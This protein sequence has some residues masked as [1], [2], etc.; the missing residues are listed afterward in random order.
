MANPVSV[1]CLADVWT[2][3]A[4]NV[5]SGTI[6]KQINSPAK[7]V[8]TYKLTGEAAPTDDDEAG[9]LFSCADY[10]IINHSVAIDVYVKAITT[11]G[12]VR[13]DL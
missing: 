10:A 5:T 13:V 2:K 8:Q 12:A 6:S 9:P 11:A 7:Y 1:T 4:T 3:V